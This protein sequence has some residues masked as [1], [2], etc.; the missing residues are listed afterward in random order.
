MS[1]FGTNSSMSLVRLLSMETPL[2]QTATQFARR[3]WVPSGRSGQ[4]SPI[5]PAPHGRRR[6]PQATTGRRAAPRARSGAPPRGREGRSCPW[7]IRAGAG[8]QQEVDCHRSTVR[9]SG[10]SLVSITHLVPG[11][12][13][14]RAGSRL[15]GRGPARSAATART[16]RQ[17]GVDPA[18]RHWQFGM[19]LARRGESADRRKLGS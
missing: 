12:T 1:D 16:F 2:L 11:R 17:R 9:K 4:V 18:S 15:R 6:P 14:G 13:G 10:R 19:H 3:P 8:F 5:D 7:P